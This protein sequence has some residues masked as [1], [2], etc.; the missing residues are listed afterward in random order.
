MFYF[1][2]LFWIT[3]LL[4]A[5]NQLLERLG[6][7]V[8]FLYSYLDDLLCP[9]IVLGFTLFV[10]QQFT[11]RKRD[12]KFSTKALIFFWLW[13]SFLFEYVFPLVDKRHYSDPWDV[14][15]YALGVLLFSKFGNRETTSS[16]LTHRFFDVKIR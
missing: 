11:Y 10:Q 13:Y 15:M 8:Y 3:F 7:K 2:K 9:P 16:L 12:Y 4:F 14:L 1:S 6:M 5:F